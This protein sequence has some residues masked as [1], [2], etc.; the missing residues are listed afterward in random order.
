MNCCKLPCFAEPSGYLRRTGAVA[1]TPAHEPPNKYAAIS[2]YAPCPGRI[3]RRTYNSFGGVDP[4]E[5]EWGCGER[6]CP[7][8]L[9]LM[10][11]SS[12]TGLNTA[13]TVL[14][15]SYRKYDPP[16]PDGASSGAI[17]AQLI[18]SEHSMFCLCTT[19]IQQEGSAHVSRRA[20]HVGNNNYILKTQTTKGST[21]NCSPALRPSAARCQHKLSSCDG[22][23]SSGISAPPS[24]LS[25]GVAG[26]DTVGSQGTMSSTS[27]C[28]K[29]YCNSGR[30]ASNL[31]PQ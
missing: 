25:L 5:N 8:G 20:A 1:G 3:P 7:R 16:V 29:P 15:V 23:E 26:M 24:L 31:T 21:C 11:G 17:P 12:S 9:F 27:P 28:C 30:S 19:G 18:V 10:L 22:E 13:T 4:G 6:A 14:F 2:R